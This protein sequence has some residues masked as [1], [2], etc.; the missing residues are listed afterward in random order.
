MLKKEVEETLIFKLLTTSF[1]SLQQYRQMTKYGSIEATNERHDPTMHS[2]M[3]V[4]SVT[5]ARR[6]NMDR[7]DKSKSLMIF[8]I[9][10]K[11]T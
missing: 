2:T 9:F 5:V 10:S 7:G 3:M 11:T 4:E 6:Q 1:R 8:T